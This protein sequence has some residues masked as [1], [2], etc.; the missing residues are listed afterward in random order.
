MEDVPKT[1]L[2]RSSMNK[3][4]RL[5]WITDITGIKRLKCYC[6]RQFLT[7]K[8]NT[9]KRCYVFVYVCVCLWCV[10][11]Y[12]HVCEPSLLHSKKDSAMAEFVF[13]SLF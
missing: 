12:M 1:Q 13:Q 11:V 9:F 3:L 7:M 8:K 5:K 2:Q 4:L 6:A 10:C